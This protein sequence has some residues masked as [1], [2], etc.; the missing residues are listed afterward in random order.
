[1]FFSEIFFI[2]K[3]FKKVSFVYKI[4][5]IFIL[6][7][8]FMKI[9][10]NRGHFLI[11]YGRQGGRKLWQKLLSSNVLVGIDCYVMWL[12]YSSIYL[13]NINFYDRKK[14]VAS[15]ISLS[16]FNI[17]KCPSTSINKGYLHIEKYSFN[18]FF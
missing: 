18:N 14:D 1:M 16:S 11:V 5:Y 12:H 15:A 17:Y 13:F 4:N 10:I 9:M 7:L 3:L 2:F 8:Y 6:S